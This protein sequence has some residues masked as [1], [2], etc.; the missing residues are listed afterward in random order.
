VKGAGPQRVQVPPGNWF[1]PP[2][3]NRSGGRGNE[4]AFGVEGRFGD[5]ASVQA[6]MEVNAEQASIA[7]GKVWRRGSDGESVKPLVSIEWVQ[8][9][10]DQSV[11]GRSVASVAVRRATGG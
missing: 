10:P 3:S 2:G 8:V 4:T 5:L 11:A 1:A 6:A 7:L 9:P